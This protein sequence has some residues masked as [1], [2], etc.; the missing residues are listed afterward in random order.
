M[1]VTKEIFREYFRKYNELYFDGILKMPSI[2]F[3]SGHNGQVG[4][5]RHQKKDGKVVNPKIYI[6][7][8]IRW[9]EED[10]ID[11]MIHEMIHYYVV[12]V[13]DY[14]GIFSHGLRFRRKWKEITKRGQ[15]IHMRYNHLKYRS[16]V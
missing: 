4:K 2:L 3:M 1:I 5:F 11:V 13:L 10:I 9:T 14:D 6:N 7:K 12:F 16:E 8:S 15:C